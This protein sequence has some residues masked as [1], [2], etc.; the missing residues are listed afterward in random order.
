MNITLQG[1]IDSSN[2]Q[3]IEAQLSSVPAGAII[4]DA[5]K[6]EYI[7]SAGLRV[8]MKL[9]KSHPEGVTVLNVSPEVYDILDMTGF[10]ELLEVHKALRQLSVEGLPVIGA[11]ATAKVYR[12]DRETV[13]KVFNPNTSVEIIR[14]ENER[15]RNAF[16]NGIPTAIAYDMVKVGDCYGSVY[17]LLDA[18]D[19]LTILENDKAHLVEHIA[20]FAHA[21]KAMHRVEVDPVKFPPTK[22]GSLAALPMLGGICTQEEIDKL[23]RLYETIPD[24]NTFLHADCHPGNVMVQNGEFVF[25][26]LMTCGSGHPVFDLGSMCTVYHMPP[27]FGSREAS[28]LTRNFTEEESAQIWDTYLRSYLET[29]DAALLAKAERQITAISAARTLFAAVFIPGLLPP[30]RIEY[31]KRVALDYVD[32]GIEPLCF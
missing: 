9:R 13:V 28:P 2:A 16:L 26:D 32:S 5:E 18:Q 24:R 22:Q 4:I 6:L 30:D 21:I 27:K 7:S 20:H 17:E 8:L 29:D 23:K 11:G 14:Q 12:I 1:R 10:T 15:G 31:M 25:V 19:F 3:A